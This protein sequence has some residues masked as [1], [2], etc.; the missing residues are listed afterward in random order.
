MRNIKWNRPLS[1][2]SQVSLLL[3]AIGFAGT[4]S[5]GQINYLTGSSCSE[6][7]SSVIDESDVTLNGDNAST[8]F[9]A[10]NGNNGGTLNWDGQI[11][12]TI[13]KFGPDENE[14]DNYLSADFGTDGDWSYTGNYSGW[15]DFFL[16]IKA[17]SEPGWAAYYFDLN[18]FDVQGDLEGTFKIPWEKELSHIEIF[19]SDTTVTVPEPGTL[20]LIG[21]GLLGLGLRRSR[22]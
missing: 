2:V 11:W 4:V 20:S 6:G 16:V 1:A 7:T 17:S 9:G 10:Y 18:D 15:S 21:L 8:C 13:S 5:A 3:V 22:Q 19:T 14:G 12:N